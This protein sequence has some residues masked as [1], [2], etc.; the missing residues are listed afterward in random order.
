MR[1][2]FVLASKEPCIHCGSPYNYLL[3]HGG[4]RVDGM[5]FNLAYQ[6]AC[7]KCRATGPVAKTAQEAVKGWEYR[8]PPRLDEPPP[9]EF[10]EMEFEEEEQIA[11]PAAYKAANEISNRRNGSGL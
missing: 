4:A 5:P 7:R 9:R 6:V 1:K 3:C 2:P 10:D 8:S 11:V